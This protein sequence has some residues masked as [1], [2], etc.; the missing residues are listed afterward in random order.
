MWS[1][2][3]N[4][5]AAARARVLARASRPALA[6]LLLAACHSAPR[7]AERPVAPV[8]VK[9]APAAPAPA[10]PATAT[11]AARG[12]A[13][14]GAAAPGAAAGGAA[15]AAVAPLRPEVPPAASTDFARAVG[16]M[17][18]GNA[19]EAELGF[20]Q[21]ALEY[22]QFAAPLANLGILY[23]RTGRLDESEQSL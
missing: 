1:P 5:R 18:A 7:E 20:K 11:A 2:G 4:K 14:P 8:P 12:A 3:S 15:G 13:V 19:T 21:I 10:Q 9:A 16:Y 6:A 17:R 22:P 23:R